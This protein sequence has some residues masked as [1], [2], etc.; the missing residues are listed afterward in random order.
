MAF[1]NIYGYDGVKQKLLEI[2]GWYDNIDELEAEGIVL[3]KGIFFSGVAGCGKSK[4]A[5]E[6]AR[7]IDDNPSII[8]NRANIKAVFDAAREMVRTTGKVKVIL[9]DELDLL[10]KDNN[11]AAR[12]LQ[13][14]IDGVDNNLGIFV[15]ATAND[16][17]CIPNALLRSGR[18]DYRLELCYPSKR[19]RKT[20]FENFFKQNN[21][22]GK[23][24]DFTYLAEITL[25]WSCADIKL[26]C[27]T[28]KLK[29]GKNITP[30]GIEDVVT[31][32]RFSNST[33][34][35]KE[36]RTYAY[37][38]HEAGHAFVAVYYDAYVHFFRAFLCHTYEAEGMTI[39]NDYD[40]SNDFRNED[41][42]I[43][44]ALGG[45]EAEKC[46]T[47]VHGLG[48]W[49]DYQNA[50]QRAF[51]LVGKLGCGNDGIKNIIPDYPRGSLTVNCS[52]QNVRNS[53][54]EYQYLLTQLEKEV[55]ELVS[56]NTEII[57]AFANVL[58]EKGVL[59]RKEAMNIM[60][61][62]TVN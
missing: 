40:S 12:I 13:T 6:F 25:G 38:V 37:A 24:V 8:T 60:H 29:L 1:E 17:Y 62:M 5:G 54:V 20:L 10:V 50:Q 22:N 52:Q 49:N 16:K 53:E 14:Q 58:M 21:I 43:R 45:P 26:V 55:K 46:V 48:G 34:T 15:I 59:T 11:S 7:L 41:A 56:R 47:G 18:F 2:K 33:L 23:G 51:M 9:I 31:D 28:I 30:D 35:P 44:V 36:E 3:P 61:Q 19:D 4:L 57:K 39:C 32:T 42:A 27:N